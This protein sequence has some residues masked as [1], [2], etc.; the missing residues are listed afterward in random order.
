MGFFSFYKLMVGKGMGCLMLIEL[1]K[2]GLYAQRE[3]AP[4]DT[5]WIAGL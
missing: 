4:S 3:S 2:E 1:L 5:V